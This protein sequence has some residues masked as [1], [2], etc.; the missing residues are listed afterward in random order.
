MCVLLILVVI[1]CFCA[2][3]PNGSV[4]RVLEWKAARSSQTDGNQDVAV[5][6]SEISNIS[7]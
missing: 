1:K 5:F 2:V 7:Y 6:I 4:T 3:S